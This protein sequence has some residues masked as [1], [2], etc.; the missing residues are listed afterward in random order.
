M[1][2]SAFAQLSDIP[3]RGYL[4]FSDDM[5][6]LRKVPDKGFPEQEMVAAHL[7]KPLTA[8]PD[9]FGTNESFGQQTMRAKPFWMTLVLTMSSSRPPSPIKR[10]NS[11]RLCL[12]N[13]E[14]VINVIP[15][16]LAKN[17]VKPTP[18]LP[19]CPKTGQV[20]Q[21]PVIELTKKRAPSSMK[22]RVPARR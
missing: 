11:T 3:T 10:V 21:V 20:L 12:R 1:V 15:P 5:D 8:I 9:P 13:Y 14:K 7:G 6:G 22:R 2:R 16:P 19:I 4:P 18:F 17:G